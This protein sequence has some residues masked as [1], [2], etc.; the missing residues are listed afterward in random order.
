ML[1]Y[2]DTA[3][4]AAK[5]AGKYAAKKAQYGLRQIKQAAVPVLLAAC[6]MTAIPVAAMTGS[7][8]ASQL[9]QHQ[10][11]YEMT[12]EYVSP[13]SEVIGV[14]GRSSYTLA[15]ECS[16][17]ATSENY[18]L[19]FIYDSGDEVTIASR[20]QA[21][22]Q[23]D[24]QLFNFELH[25]ESSYEPALKLDG[26]AMLG[27]GASEKGEAYFS[28]EPTQ[29]MPIPSDT[30]FPVSHLLALLDK[31]RKGERQFSAKIFF[32]AEPDRALKTAV[33]FI[34][35]KKQR[36]GQ[37]FDH[38][39]IQTEYWPVRIAY[40]DPSSGAPEP[41]YEV[42]LELQENGLVA[43]YAID[44]GDLVIRANLRSLESKPAADCSS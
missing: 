6:F 28:V 33:A 29:A 39:L 12:L 40:F 2:D 20:Y 22:E 16:G 26:Y 23:A 14:D 3:K 42:M 7:E 18:L 35:D 31:A 19:R 30:L 17:L 38:V 10:A 1:W 8:P 9:V 27:E 13:S 11:S 32:G 21:W 37:G 24:G 25:E 4:Y 5:Y 34:S 43:G 36:Q 41:D 15:D 44:Y